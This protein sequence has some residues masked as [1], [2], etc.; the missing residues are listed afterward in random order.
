M[1]YHDTFHAL[2]GLDDASFRRVMRAAC[3]YS[4]TGSIATELGAIEQVVFGILRCKLDADLERYQRRVEAGRKGGLAK[5]SNAKQSLANLPTTTITTTITPTTD[6]T[7]TT[8]YSSNTCAR[9]DGEEEFPPSVGEVA[10][11]IREK[12]LNVDAEDFIRRCEAADW[13]DG[14]GRPIMNWRIYLTG[15]A[16][17]AMQ[18][19][20]GR[21]GCHGH[22]RHDTRLPPFRGPRGYAPAR[23]RPIAS[24][25]QASQ[26]RGPGW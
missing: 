13:K 6:T 25:R 5:A 23:S 3:E 4:E 21:A 11:Y 1:M 22:S 15:Y 20:G 8:G 2:D 9:E 7:I 24:W 14:Q 10:E 12:G 18:P 17:K 16:L 26:P 19:Q